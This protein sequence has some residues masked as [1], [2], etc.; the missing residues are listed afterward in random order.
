MSSKV[1]SIFVCKDV[2]GVRYLMDDFTLECG[3]DTYNRFM[4]FAIPMVLIYP[5]GVPL[6]FFG[7]L[8][9]NRWKLNETDVMERLGFL[10]KAYDKTVWWF[11]LVMTH[12]IHTLRYIICTDH[13]HDIC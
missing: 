9:T 12:L 3:D 6:F 4:G 10:Y 7:L 5:I 1:M 2:D 11:E 13:T 8:F